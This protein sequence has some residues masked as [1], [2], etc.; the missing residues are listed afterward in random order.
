M[1]VF[2]VTSECFVRSIAQLDDV[3]YVVSCNH[4][5]DNDDHVEL[6]AFECHEPYRQ[7]ESIVIDGFSPW[8]LGNIIVQQY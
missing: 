6:C 8:D 5:S 7:L 1:S 3:V 4:N 2:D